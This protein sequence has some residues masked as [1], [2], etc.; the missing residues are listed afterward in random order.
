MAATQPPPASR[1]YRALCAFLRVAFRL[2]TRTRVSGM[3]HVPPEGPLLIVINHLSMLDVPLIMAT[4]P[5]QPIVAMPKRDYEKSILG[6][7]I[8]VMNLDAI[9]VERDSGANLQALRAVLDCLKNG[10]LIGLA[11]EGGRSRT[12]GLIEGKPGVAYIAL[13][14]EVMVLPVALW[15]QEQ[16]VHLWPRLRRPT[17]HL[18]VG[19]PFRVERDPY[20]SRRENMEAGTTQ[21]MQAIAALLPPAYQGVYRQ[22]PQREETIHA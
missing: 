6:H 10:G 21:I 17:I 9:Y 5:R 11:P 20:K 15:G 2:L 7:F 13:Q 4:F 1:R 22:A 12:G 8:N 14:S 19:P 18:Q 3:E 16:A